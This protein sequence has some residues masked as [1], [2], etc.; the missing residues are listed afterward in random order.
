MNIQIDDIIDMLYNK[1]NIPRSEIGK[2]I[3]S[4]FKVLRSSIIEKSDKEVDLMYI[5]TFKPTPF[6][7]K[8]LKE[9]K[10]DVSNSKA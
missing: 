6:R 9:K 4:P 5:G 8:Q 1:Y 10:E 3:R 2:I 7:L